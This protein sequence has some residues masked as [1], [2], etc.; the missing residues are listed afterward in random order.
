MESRGEWETLGADGIAESGAH[1]VTEARRIVG[2]SGHKLSLA[3]VL[4]E[5]GSRINERRKSLKLSQ[6][7]LAKMAGLDRAYISSLENGKQNVTLGVILKLSE[8]LDL[9]LWDLLDREYVLSADC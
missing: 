3:Q 4:K 9:S 7:Q 6:E 8:A 1:A 2:A 5:I